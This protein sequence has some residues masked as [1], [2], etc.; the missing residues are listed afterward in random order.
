[1]DGAE[2]G[3]VAS[4]HV[5]VKSL[6]GLGPAHLTELLVHVV[7]AGAGVVAEPDTEVLDLEG[8]L[9]VD[10][11][12]MSTLC[13]SFIGAVETYHV[14]ADDLT[15]GLLDLAELGQEVPEPRLS[16]DS[17]GRKDAHAVQLGRGVGLGG[18]MT[19]DDLVLGETPY[20]ISVSWL[21][22]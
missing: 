11:I 1:M 7:G 4:S 3:T 17:V 19:P 10:L 9:L 21:S 12:R 8:A 2:T 20:G 22:S 14:E 5:L 13:S 18:Q 15:V 6:N 16:H